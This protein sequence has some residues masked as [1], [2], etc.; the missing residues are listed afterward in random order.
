MNISVNL[1]PKTGL[2]QALK[3]AGID[4]PESVAKL[5]VSGAIT[6]E[7]CRFIRENM[8]ETLQE[9]NLS[10]A[11]FEKNKIDDL[12]FFDAIGLVS[13]TLPDS[14][15]EI[16]IHIF[17]RCESLTSIA[18]HPDNPAFASENGILF[19]KDKTEL[20]AF[21]AG[22]QGEYTI[23]DSV[24]KIGNEVFTGCLTRITIPDSVIEIEWCACDGCHVTVHPDNPEY[25]SEDG[26]LFNKDKTE[27]I[28]YPKEKQGDYVI[29][30]TVI[31]FGSMAFN[32]CTDLTSVTIPHSVETIGFSAFS[33]CTGLTEI[34][35][36]DSVT[37]IEYAA[38]SN[39]TGL[40]SVYIPASVVKIDDTA[41]N[42]CTPVF[43]VNPNNPCYESDEN[44]KLQFRTK[45]ASGKIDHIDWTFADSVLTIDGVGA[46]RDYDD[47]SDF[48][49]LVSEEGRSP[50]YHLSPGI[51]SVVFR[52]VGKSGI[53]MFS[54]CINLATVTFDECEINN[55]YYE[56]RKAGEIIDRAFHGYTRRDVFNIK[57]WFANQAPCM[58]RE[59]KRR[60]SES[61]PDGMSHEEWD[62][63]LARMI[64]CF[65][66]MH[67]PLATTDDD[68][69]KGYRE[70]LKREGFE[71]FSK[72]YVYLC[73]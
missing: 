27:L 5:T 16:G 10:E 73:C 17:G 53:N 29:P 66:E 55:G 72:Y 36:P 24:V 4:N 70:K 15:F 9:L 47:Y 52:G 56:F 41:F 3:N 62:A 46:I 61:T 44:G 45:N 35:I 65:S 59:F 12:T 54:E 42:H 58:L 26:V 28:T 39:C 21:P 37:E 51:K 22:R 30:N 1:T 34:V 64:F 40:K 23:P 32:D 48:E 13:V 67:P 25:S 50:W 14:I 20:I 18:I 43:E 8:R 33:G 68:E 19:N 71:L 49:N 63:I 7:D 11:S 57:R 31:Q 60:S 69:K 2:E 38:F 6:K